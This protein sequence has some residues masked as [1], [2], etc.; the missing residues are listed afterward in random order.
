M[1]PSS[2]SIEEISSASDS[3]EQFNF[4]NLLE[5]SDEEK[6]ND[7]YHKRKFVNTRPIKDSSISKGIFL[8]ESL[9][10]RR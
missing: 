4:K 7:E 8:L 3:E 6:D 9:I 10:C 1:C 2:N 5:D